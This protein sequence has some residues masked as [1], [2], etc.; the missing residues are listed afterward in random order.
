[1]ST[2]ANG[3]CAVV[4]VAGIAAACS[5][6]PSTV[7]RQPQGTSG[8]QGYTDL[9]AAN[10]GRTAR[11]IEDEFLRLEARIPGFGGMFKDID[12]V[13]TAYLTDSMQ[14][15][16]ARQ[17][18][19]ASDSLFEGEPEVRQAVRDGRVRFRSGL[20]TFSQLVG[21]QRLALRSLSPTAVITADADESSNRVR[22]G[23]SGGISAVAVNQLLRDAGIPAEALTIE[24]EA[25]IQLATLRDHFPRGTAGGMQ[26]ADMN[27]PDMKLCTLGFNVT[28]STLEEGL[29]TAAHCNPG[30]PWS[31]M[32]GT[33]W[34]NVGGPGYNQ[35]M[36]IGAILFNPPW[37]RR[38]STCVGFLRCTW[39]DAMFVQYHADKVALSQHSVAATTFVGENN[40]AGSV[41]ETSAW[42]TP[43]WEYKTPYVGLVVDK[44]ARTTGWTRGTIQRTCEAITVNF[45]TSEA[46]R[47]LCVDRVTN[48]AV[49]D[50]DSGGPV[51]LPAATPGGY[52][53]AVGVVVARVVDPSRDYGDPSDG[54]IA[55]CIAPQTCTYWYANWPAIEEHLGN[56]FH[57]RVQ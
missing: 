51:F 13:V 11:G 42:R 16:L 21:W 22:V 27:W 2:W 28:A 39:T 6:G 15:P 19:A 37:E 34:Q 18:I 56:L 4:L 25:A 43:V 12:G 20:W 24:T 17:V 1:M 55:R 7:R 23:I 26:I 54:Y 32:G 38:D 10:A 33:V 41:E 48:S 8:P 44:V 35:Q 30:S 5:D 45:N 47:I 36:N 9:A 52:T 49:G 57:A 46:Y 3:R 53:R 29:L 50:G 31:G 40:R 14:R